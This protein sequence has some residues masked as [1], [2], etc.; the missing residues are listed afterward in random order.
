M[1]NHSLWIA[2]NYTFTLQHIPFG[3]LSKGRE[4]E[5]EGAE[6]LNPQNIGEK[7]CHK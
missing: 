5:R 1:L 3:V 4:R 6:C 7:K 2:F